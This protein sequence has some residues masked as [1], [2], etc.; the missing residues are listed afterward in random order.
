[1]LFNVNRQCALIAL[2]LYPTFTLCTSEL[3]RTSYVG[4]I[5]GWIGLGM[6]LG[7]LVII[8]FGSCILAWNEQRRQT[9][10]NSGGMR[11]WYG[12]DSGD[13]NR[14]PTYEAE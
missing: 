1:M 11:T 13:S 2:F 7:V 12:D 6:F 3:S 10:R 9:D 14:G 8:I 4:R 5:C